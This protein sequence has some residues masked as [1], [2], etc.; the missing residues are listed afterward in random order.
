MAK[1]L[2]LLAN[3][4]S[5]KTKL[6]TELWGITKALSDGDFQVE[7]YVTRSSGDA[8]RQV[9]ERAEEFDVIVAC[10]GDGTL[11]EVVTGALRAHFEGAIAFLPCGT[12][13]DLAASLKLPKSLTKGA[14]MIAKTEGKLLDFGSFNR[15]RYFTYIAAFGAFTDVAYSTDQKL[16]NVFGHAAYV[17]EA[18][19]HLQELRS[20]HMK[21]TCDGEVYEDDFLFGAAANALSLG[22][23]M[24]LKKDQVDM[25]D[26]FHEVI[27]IR[28]PK[29][30]VEM[31]QLSRELL[32][33]NFEN[34]E[35][36][37]LKG[38]KITFECDQEIP[39]CLD[40]EY[41]GRYEKATVRNLHE[42]LKVIYP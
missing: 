9:Q 3:P 19:S 32:S 41:A 23:V 27:L 31:A 36:L 37:L 12:T 22:G 30:A 42:R 15:T 25:A 26:G 34:K 28:N 20:Y 8:T 11:N 29:N 16:K 18:I 10:G 4:V 35:V 39:W 38:K 17:S 21:V 24:K 14:E 2:L 33:R 40:G 13:N 6:K 5:G 1:K 7:T